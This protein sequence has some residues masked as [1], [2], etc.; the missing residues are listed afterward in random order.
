MVWE[1]GSGE[2]M[3]TG[4]LLSYASGTCSILRELGRPGEPRGRRGQTGVH[5]TSQVTVNTLD[6]SGLVLPQGLASL[7]NGLLREKGTVSGA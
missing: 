1:Q 6:P 3:Q 4:T 7:S 2:R 5:P